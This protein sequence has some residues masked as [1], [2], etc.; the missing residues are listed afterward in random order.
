MTM[1]TSQRRKR[2]AAFDPVIEDAP[3]RNWTVL[4]QDPSVPGSQGRALT[5]RVTVPA[6]RLEAGPKGHRIYVIDFDSTRKTYYRP[7]AR[8]LY[9]DRYA[10]VTDIG[11]LVGD[12]GFHQQNVYAI[13]MATLGVFQSALGRP[14]PWGFNSPGH[15]LK[16]AP[17]A[18]ADANAYYSRESESLSLGYFTGDSGRTVFTCLSHDIV[19]HETAHALLDGLRPC[20]LRPSHADQ[21]AFHEGFSDV[22][23]LLSVLQSTELVELALLGISDR[24][25]LIASKDLTF[26]ALQADSILFKLAK[27]FG[28]ELSFV[29]GDA[30]R[31]SVALK[32]SRRIL[33]QEEFQ[34]EHRRGEVLVAAIAQAFLRVWS[35]RLELL[36]TTRGLALNRMVVADE[37]SKAARQLLRIAI[38][39][40]DYLPAVDMVFGDYVSAMITADLQLYPDPEYRYRDELRQSFRSFGIEPSSRKRADGAWDPPP[41]ADGLRY[42]GLHF[43]ELQSDPSTLFRFLWENRDRL[44]IDPD[45]FT[46]VTSV[47]PSVRVGSDGFVLRETVVEYLQTMRVVAKDLDGLGIKRPKG[48]SKQTY[49]PLYGGGTLIFNEF[50]RVKFH[51][52]TGVRSKR[53]SARLQSLYNR[54]A[55]NRDAGERTHFAALHRRRMLGGAGNAQEQW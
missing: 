3:A 39:A 51:I 50:G 45:A 28:R 24:R 52:G 48:L 16:I 18:F 53:Q 7:R 4:A 42:E 44:G 43:T 9:T 20:L 55:F 6:E 2:R 5:T 19:A 8:D 38:R 31:H 17:H 11:H 35:K 22:V 14:V 32:S 37:G 15:Q 21:A 40:L 27:Q 23:A 36:G 13:A 54:G 29:R 49:L 47:R 34:E 26:E 12:P 25:N 10:R 30:L 33:D 46:R 1:A 41:K